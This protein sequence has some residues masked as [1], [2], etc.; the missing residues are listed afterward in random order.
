MGNPTRVRR[1]STPFL[2]F[3]F[4]MA[5]APFFAGCVVVHAPLLYSSHLALSTPS[6]RALHVVVVM[7]IFVPVLIFFFDDVLFANARVRVGTSPCTHPPLCRGDDG[8]R[9]RRLGYTHMGPVCRGEG[10]GKATRTSLHAWKSMSKRA[11]GREGRALSLPILSRSL[12]LSL[13]VVLS[14]MSTLG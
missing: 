8:R 11:V 12:S 14:P 5:L 6:P 7:M 9:Q 4:M 3:Q 2:C 13:C 1:H 10:K